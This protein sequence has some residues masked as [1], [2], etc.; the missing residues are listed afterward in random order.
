MIY[1]VIEKQD[2]SCY[3]HADKL[4]NR[5]CL[6]IFCDCCIKHEQEE[7]RY[8][9]CQSKKGTVKKRQRAML[10]NFKGISLLHPSKKYTKFCALRLKKKKNQ[11]NENKCSTQKPDAF[12]V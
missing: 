12:F 9:S 10:F 2:T 7:K 6:I 1:V 3:A 4:F 8:Q 5:F 11:K